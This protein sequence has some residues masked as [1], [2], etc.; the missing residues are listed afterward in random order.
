MQF[1]LTQEEVNTLKQQSAD[2]GFKRAEQILTETL[3]GKDVGISINVDGTSVSI[4]DD[5]NKDNVWR[6]LVDL[7]GVVQKAKE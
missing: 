4:F 3:A 5:A 2:E 7:A 1:I 6:K